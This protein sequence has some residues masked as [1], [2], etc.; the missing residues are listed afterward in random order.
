MFAAVAAP[1]YPTPNHGATSSMALQ[2]RRGQIRDLLSLH[3]MT[4]QELA[5]QTGTR[6][7]DLTDDLE[8]LRRSLGGALLIDPASCDHCDFTFHKRAR[9]SAPSR[10]PNCRSERIRGPWL[11]VTGAEA[12]A[13]ARAPSA[14]GSP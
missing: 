2:T 6:M 9:F 4:L 13:P 14:E 7:A 1:F 10:C 5:R 8:H 11:S 12:D 3:P